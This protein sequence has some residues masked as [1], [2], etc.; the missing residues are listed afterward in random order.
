MVTINQLAKMA[1]DFSG[2]YLNIVHEKGPVGVMGRNSDNT[3]IREKLGWSPKYKL[4]EGL[5]ITFD[6]IK[7]RYDR[8]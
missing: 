7:S 8:A 5:K 3:L 6:W 2:R 1:I 4:K